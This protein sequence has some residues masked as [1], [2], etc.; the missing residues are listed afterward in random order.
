MVRDLQPFIHLRK[1]AA[2]RA[3]GL[4]DRKRMN[5]DHALA[6]QGLRHFPE[7]VHDASIRKEF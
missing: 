5:P 3:S 6:V 1:A 7:N 2:T 4:K